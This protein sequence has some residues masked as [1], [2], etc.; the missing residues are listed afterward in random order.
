MSDVESRHGLSPPSLAK[1]ASK[2][3]KM[4]E[5][6]YG[7]IGKPKLRQK[8]VYSNKPPV[9]PFKA[10]HTYMM[11]N[12]NDMR[13]TGTGIKINKRKRSKQLS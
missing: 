5:P 2:E 4:N 10:Q 13:D 8:D 11:A 6:D 3:Y 12:N 1:K 9:S 7:V